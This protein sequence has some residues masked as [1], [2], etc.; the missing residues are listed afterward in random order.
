ME[1]VLNLTPGEANV[2][3]GVTLFPQEAPEPGLQGGAYG[4]I[5]SRPAMNQVV[6][7][8]HDQTRTQA[9]RF[10]AT[11][12]G[13]APG[14]WFPRGRMAASGPRANIEVPP[15]VAYGS[16]FVDRSSVYGLG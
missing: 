15:H 1:N 5:P 10:Q 13:P 9:D 4:L 2:R 16:L 14:A 8:H 7:F 6:V 3:V 12:E 11:L